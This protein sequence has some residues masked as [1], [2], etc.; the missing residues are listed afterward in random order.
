MN[1][2]LIVCDTWRRDHAGNAYGNDWIRTPNVSRFASK[3][4]VFEN[5]YCAS[6]PTLPCRRDILTG[7][8]EFPW[9]GW[10][11]L[12]PNDVTLPAVLGQSEKL[13]YFITDVYHHWGRDAGNYWRDFTGFDLVRGQERDGYITDADVQFDH[14][15]LRYPPH[16][17]PDEPH[18]RNCQLLRK[19]EEDWF[20]AQV[21]RRA[22]RWIQHNAAH[23]DFFLMIDAFDPH[24][25]WDP[26]RYYTD[27]YGDPDF[28]GRELQVAPYAPYEGKLTPEELRHVQALYAGEVTLMDRWLG[29]FLNQ[30]ELMGLMDETMIILTTDHG[31]HNGD[32]GRTGKNWTL[33]EEISHIPLMVWHP[34]LGHGARPKQLVQPIDFFPTVLDACGV[35]A[36][37]GLHGRSLIPYLK[38]PDAAHGR[39]AILFGEFANAC[40]VTD[41]EHVL[42]QGVDAANPPVYSYSLTRN[43]WSSDDWGP[44]DGVRRIV[45][46]KNA[47]TAGEK[48]KTRL[49]HLPTDPNEERDL[50][51]DRPDDLVRLQRLMARKLQEI[52]APAEQLARWALDRLA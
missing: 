40:N 6:Y 21:F 1:V 38:D 30:I 31:T 3:A 29:H 49:F 13:S 22:T 43:K 41:G 17:R 34:E 14:R 48:N 12:E 20:C 23:D 47:N 32:H 26:P 16:V 35:D 45:G 18:F 7:R 37:D 28:A 52:D 4:A 19:D 42:V 27:M 46:P 33:L 9:R 39:D 11:G 36:P 2:I 8:Y 24:E 5:A 25:P 15:A 50:A 44:F 51:A 10:G